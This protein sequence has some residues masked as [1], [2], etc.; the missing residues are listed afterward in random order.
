MYITDIGTGKDKR[1]KGFVKW[2]GG[3]WSWMEL[4]MM[5]GGK[6]EE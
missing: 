3:K 6:A 1:A 2:R 5:K 4:V